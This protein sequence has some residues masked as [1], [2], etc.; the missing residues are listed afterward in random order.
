MRSPRLEELPAP[1][2]GKTGWP[3]TEETPPLSADA[4][5]GTPW[6]KASVVTPSYNQGQF[7]EETIRSVLLQGYPNLEYIVVDGGS[8]DD[9]V[10]I[11]RKYEKWLAYWV[12][13]PDRGQSD[14]INKGWRRATGEVWAWLNSDDV[15]L[16]RALERAA[17]TFAQHPDV[18]M[19]YGSS[20]L[21]NERGEV[22]GHLRA[23]AFDLKELVRVNSVPQPSTFLRGQAAVGAGYLSESLHLCMD[24][25]LWL[26]VALRGRVVNLDEA[27]SAMRLHPQS[28]TCTQLTRMN[29]EL[30]DI[31][32]DFLSAPDLPAE[33]REVRHALLSR[34]RWVAGAMLW[35]GGRMDEGEKYLRLALEEGRLD[36][37]EEI[38]VIVADAAVRS[39][40]TGAA[41][42]V[43]E[44]FDAFPHAKPA[45]RLSEGWVSA[46]L[47][48]ESVNSPSFYGHALRALRYAPTPRVLR[49][50]APLIL[51]R[52]TGAKVQRGIRRLKRTWAH[53]P[54]GLSL[55]E[56]S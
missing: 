35:F 37:R 49:A 47:A 43:G 40:A 33:L 17:Q 10:E 2:K 5:G 9:S 15:Y 38:A 18:E 22:E 1:P 45:A 26:R 28:K 20:V 14:A 41:A 24:Y 29:A 6:P 16:R 19:V 7:I 51:T 46:L 12:S 39:D 44:F 13:E 54:V 25:D 34:Q 8:T 56:L 48:K 11:I 52:V 42:K 50:V 32:T 53:S 36:D 31:A 27:L 55:S 30:A 3:W 4:P 23:P 21:V